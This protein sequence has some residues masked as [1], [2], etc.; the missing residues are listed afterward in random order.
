MSLSKTLAA[1]YCAAV[2]LLQ[3]Y[4]V[5][6]TTAYNERHW[7]FMNY[8]MYSAA[9][10]PGDRVAEVK[11]VVRPCDGGD[12]EPFTHADARLI[13]FQFRKAVMQAGDVLGN[14][15]PATSAR[16]VEFLRDRIQRYAPKP[17]CEWSVWSKLYE[18]GPGGLE[19]PGLPWKKAGPWPIPAA[20]AAAADSARAA[21]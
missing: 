1:A 11:L 18:I 19:L 14:T 10:G 6:A 2:I 8:P 16:A 7:P 12:P 17:A 4:K 3:T 15:P 20:P 9:Y 13:Y 21:G 5:F